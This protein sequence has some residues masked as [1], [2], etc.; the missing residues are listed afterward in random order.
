VTVD[1][2]TVVNM[3]NN[4]NS[5]VSVS[6]DA[7]GEVKVL[8]GNYQAQYG[9]M[10][11]ANIEIITKSG[12][13]QFHGLG[14]YFKR[15]EQFNANNFFNNQAGLARPIYRFNTWT[16]N[17]GGP[18]YLPGK[19]AKMRDKLFFFW[20]QEFWPLRT[21]SALVRLTVPTALERTGDFSQSV[22]QNGA[23]IAIRDPTTGQPVPGNRVPA[24]QLNTNG[25]AL[26]KA[27]PA[28]NFTDI[29]ISARRYNY[30]FQPDQ[31]TPLN[32]STL[33]VDYLIS[34]KDHVT[35]SMTI[36]NEAIQN[37]L[38]NTWAQLVR[39]REDHNKAVIF[40][41]ERIFS[42]SLINEM[43]FGF[44]RRP[45]DDTLN[46]IRCSET[47]AT[48]WASRWASSTRRPIP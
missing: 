25:L 8:T 5:P 44:V 35:A 41:H 15:H 39:D 48:P 43:S 3:R 29:S 12:T 14:S 46:P 36:H 18:I 28:V 16:Y 42:P 24:N 33:K 45:E 19:M 10:S 9:R 20:S 26:L 23:L 37:F 31:R 22:D 11:G 1:G 38:D 32:T 17:I 40:R 27:L 2:L 34:S 7:V 4:F 6:L 47:S 13:R 30:L 21:P